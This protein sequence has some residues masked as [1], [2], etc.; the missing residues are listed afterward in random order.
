MANS[1]DGGKRI[2]AKDV[3]SSTAVGAASR[4]GVA[5]SKQAKGEQLVGKGV[6]TGAAKGAAP[7][8]RAG[9]GNTIMTIVVVAGGLIAML[10]IMLWASGR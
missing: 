5:R 4:L 3:A 6:A 2:D 10:A 7:G 8:A 9:G 1:S